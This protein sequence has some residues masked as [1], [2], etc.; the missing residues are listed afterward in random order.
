MKREIGK[1]AK[2]GIAMTRINSTDPDSRLMRMKR[3]DF[4]NGYN[5][6][7]ATENQ[8]IIATTVGN[9]ASDINE[10]IPVLGA[11]EKNF[12]TKPKIVLADKGYSSE[13]NYE[14]LQDQGIDGYIPHP[15]LAQNLEG[16]KYNERKDAYTDKE[17][18]IYLFKQ[19]SESKKPRDR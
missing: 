13:K 9:A 17:G 15:K 18:D 6:Q 12:Q 2:E 10:L 19:L 5:P 4:A 11:I 8:F 16:W 14:Y 7:L 1:K 3:K